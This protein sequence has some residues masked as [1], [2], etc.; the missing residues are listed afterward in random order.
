LQ[1]GEGGE[2][3]YSTAKIIYEEIFILVF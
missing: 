3:K 2:I 1:A